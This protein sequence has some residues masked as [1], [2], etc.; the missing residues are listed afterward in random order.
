MPDDILH[1][2]ARRVG[3]KGPGES[4]TGH[5]A[6]FRQTPNHLVGQIASVA[7]NRSGIG[8][9]GDKRL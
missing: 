8:V 9:R 6:F 2:A 1:M 4:Q 3:Q 7:G 5:A